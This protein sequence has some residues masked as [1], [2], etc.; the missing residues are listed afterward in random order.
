M[1]FAP[2]LSEHPG[3]AQA[4]GEVIGQ[5]AEALGGEPPD[6]AVLFVTPPH[7]ASMAEI[8]STVVEL[9]APGHLIGATAV[10]VLGGV[11][12]VEERPAVSLWAASG[13]GAVTPVRL[14]VLELPSGPIISGLPE[15][16][17]PETTGDPGA[18]PRVLLLL[19]DPY[20]FPSA[21]FLQ[22]L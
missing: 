21:A 10:A 7:I 3:A 2:A 6:L 15:M 13:L 9:L 5:V 14:E 8:Q 17:M 4:T 22:H 18:E 16:S 11:R 20:S 12:E 19:S 1:P